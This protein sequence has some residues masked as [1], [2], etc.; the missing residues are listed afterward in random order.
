MRLLR[1]FS[2]AMLVA[3]AFVL[4]LVAGH[5]LPLQS[6]QAQGGSAIQEYVL[7][8]GVLCYTLSGQGAAFSCVNG[9]SPAGGR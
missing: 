6:A 4:G 7:P 8:N 2:V 5:T 9:A 3:L 1:V